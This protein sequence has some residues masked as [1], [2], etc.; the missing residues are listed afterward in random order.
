MRSL[1][2][3][4]RII[5]SSAQDIGLTKKSY[6]FNQLH[7]EGF[8]IETISKSEGV[9]MKSATALV[10]GLLALAAGG[11]A[12]AANLILNGSF[13]KASAGNS[14][15]TG[16]G[17]SLP[18]G[19]TAIADWTVF[20]GLSSDGLA[21]LVNGNGYGVSTPYGSYF[22]DLTGYHDK[23]PYFGVEQTIA[24]TEG[25]SYALTFRLGVDQ[26]SDIYNGPIGVTAKAGS[27]SKVFDNYDPSGTGNIW[28]VFTLDFTAKSAS[29]LISIQ[30]E[31]GDQYIGLDDVVV[32]ARPTAEWTAS[33]SAVPETSTWAMMIVSFAG[34]AL[35]GYRKAKKNKTSPA[36][37]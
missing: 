13:E 18:S 35:V 34:L 23:T 4:R 24:T 32:R 12:S 1:G 33:P 6:G 37:V 25:Q 20:G 17:E 9:S 27:R 14:L 31:E 8:E 15:P 10:V 26:S 22:L 19:S 11:S 21:W 3:R 5:Y 28:K 16:N 2:P 7:C 36:A 30:G 29:T